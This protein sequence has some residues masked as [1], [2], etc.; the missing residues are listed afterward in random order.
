MNHLFSA[1][2][3]NQLCFHGYFIL[4]F[5]IILYLSWFIFISLFFIIKLF[6]IENIDTKNQVIDKNSLTA[7]IRQEVNKPAGKFDI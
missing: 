5:I 7:G 1:V 6:L 2:S 4:L 3:V